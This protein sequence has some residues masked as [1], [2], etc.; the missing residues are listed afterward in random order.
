MTNQ[1]NSNLRV[2]RD[3]L[4]D[5][6]CYTVYV[7]TERGHFTSV[8]SVTVRGDDPPTCNWS[9]MGERS[10]AFTGDVAAAIQLSVKL[11]KH[12]RNPIAV[13]RIRDANLFS[14]VEMIG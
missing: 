7:R 10:Q 8:G 13:A 5:G 1:S 9:G 11:M 4:Y 14:G 3:E 6:P 12:A 2:K